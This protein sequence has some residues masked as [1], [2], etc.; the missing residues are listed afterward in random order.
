M[1]AY[2]GLAMNP[3]RKLLILLEPL[4]SSL[5]GVKRRGNLCCFELLSFAT[6]LGNLFEAN[7]DRHVAALL[8]M[9]PMRK[10]LI[11]LESKISSLRG[12]KRRGNL[13][14]PRVNGGNSRLD[15]TL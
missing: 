11:L 7:G 12:A 10:S 13:R 14:L 2:L 6:F 15:R 4:I 9:N 8:S 1:S 5:R 3:A